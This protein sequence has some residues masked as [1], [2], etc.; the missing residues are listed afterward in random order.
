MNKRKL[1]RKKVKRWKLLASAYR[2]RTMDEWKNLSVFKRFQ[3]R[4]ARVVFGFDFKELFTRAF[5]DDLN[6]KDYKCIGE[7]W[8]F[9]KYK[10]FWIVELEN[11]YCL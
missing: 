1:R 5:W 9:V 8:F 10:T 6:P 7:W 3:I 4:I 11:H 2:T